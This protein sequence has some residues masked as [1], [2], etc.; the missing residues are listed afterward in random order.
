MLDVSEKAKSR[1]GWGAYAWQAARTV[2]DH[3]IRLR[4]RVDDGEE[5]QFYGRTC[6]IA[7]VGTLV[8]GLQL[9]PEAQPDDGL[10]EVLVFDPTTVVDYVRTS[11]GIVRRRPTADD[12]VRTLFRGTKVVV[13]THRSRPRQIDGDLVE[14]GYG[15]VVRLLPKALDVKVPH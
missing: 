2:R 5:I 14:D 4:V 15:F 13:T 9:V 8:G 10:L 3:P 11:W 1:L 7:N 6:V 12:P